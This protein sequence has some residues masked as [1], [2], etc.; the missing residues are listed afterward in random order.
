MYGS[1]IIFAYIS[2]SIVAAQHDCKPKDCYDLKC[3]TIST[4]K[5]GPH[6]IY[7]GTATLPNMNVSCDQTTDGG[8]WIIYQRRFNGSVNFARGWVPYKNGFGDYGDHTAETW[9]GNEKLFQMQQAYGSIKVNLRIEATSFDGDSCFATC[10]GFKMKSE[11][12]DYK[13]T[14]NTVNASIPGMES[15]LD[16]HKDIAFKANDRYRGTDTC[17]V[18]YTGAWW[19]HTCASFYFNGGYI[20]SK[21]SNYTSIFFSSFKA[22]QTLK[23]SCM[24]F[25]PAKETRICH[26]PCKHGGT[27]RYLAAT[28]ASICVCTSNYCGNDCEIVRPCKKA[29]C[30]YGNATQP[31]KWEP[32]T[33]V[34]P[35]TTAGATDLPATTTDGATDL[36]ATTTDGATDLPATTTDGVTED[37]EPEKSGVV[38]LILLLL[39]ILLLTAATVGFVIYRQK[40]TR[41]AE[42]AAVAEEAAERDRLLAEEEQVEGLGDGMFSFFGW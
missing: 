36:P 24:M 7:P 10:Y 5:D 29:K 2:M 34:D 23:T 18:Q 19:F 30:V 8:G 22:Q 20:S 27:C 39:L 26:N 14:W 11:T 6:T 28:N 17:V 15:D 25:R 12:E 35:T 32:D 21:Q 1:V 41:A 33:C 9:L 40:K 13:I 31:S 4:G 16:K 42:E 3:F 37:T 38:G